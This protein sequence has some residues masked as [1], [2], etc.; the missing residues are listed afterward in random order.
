MSA[1]NPK[2]LEQIRNLIADVPDFPKPGILFRDI[3]PLLADAKAFHVAI[4]LMSEAAAEYKPAKLVAIE[5]RGF[6]LASAIA[7][8]LSLGLVLVRKPGKL[9][10][11]TIRAR[12]EL[13]Y[14]SDELE[15]HEDSLKTLDRVLL[16]DDVLATGGTLLTALKLC[17]DLHA[18]VVGA[19]TLIELKDLGGRTQLGA[20]PYQSILSL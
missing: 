2:K 3:T 9:P 18:K 15:I 17:Q 1:L 20:L 6:I 7:Q 8:R 10:R 5:S 16:V 14:G 12:Y 13:E 19:L 4:E 11:K